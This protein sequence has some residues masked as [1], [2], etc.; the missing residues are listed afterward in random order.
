MPCHLAMPY[1]TI[2]VRQ[3]T[4]STVVAAARSYN[5]H[6]P[7]HL[8]ALTLSLNPLTNSIPYSLMHA[9]TVHLLILLS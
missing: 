8:L 3:A 4:Q 1:K 5:T 9:S 6:L 2:S 7:A